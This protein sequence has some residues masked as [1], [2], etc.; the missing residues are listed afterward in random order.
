MDQFSRTRLLLGQ[1]GMDRLKNSRV[2][3][4]GVGGVGGYTFE[5]LVRS[6][7]GTV[8]IFDGDSVDL[9]NLNRQIIATR[10]TV[11]RRKVEAARERALS[12]NPE[13]R[14]NAFDMFFLPENSGEVDFSVYDHHILFASSILQRTALYFSCQAQ[15]TRN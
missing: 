13:C 6:G 3:L 10:E 5:A 1:E 11:G 12:I 9:T 14:V 2:A 4:F 8:D 15:S 7:V